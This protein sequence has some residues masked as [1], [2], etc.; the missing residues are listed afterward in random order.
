MNLKHILALGLTAAVIFPAAHGLSVSADTI[1][2]RTQQ[3]TVSTEKKIIASSTDNTSWKLYDDGELEINCTGTAPYFGPDFTYKNEVKS[4][5]I[6]ENVTVLPNI[7]FMNYPN[8]TTVKVKGSLSIGLSAFEGCKQLS[9]I[10][11]FKKVTTIDSHAFKNCINIQNLTFPEGVDSI[12]QSAFENCKGLEKVTIS[13]GS[14]SI[15]HQ[16]F[17]NCTNLSDL[18]IANGASII[19]EFAFKNCTN[20]STIAISNSAT[21]IGQGAFS[22]CSAL[23]TITLP[24]NL[25]AINASTFNGCK[26][27]NSITIPSKVTTIGEQAFLNCESLKKIEIPSNV[28]SIGESAFTDCT[29]LSIA[30]IPKEVTYIAP[31][32]FNGCTTLLSIRYTGTTAQWNN[33]GVTLLPPK[34]LPESL[35]NV[36]CNYTPNHKHTYC[37]YT[38]YSTPKST[39]KICSVCG[40]LQYENNT[41]PSPSPT[42]EHKW[43]GWTTISAATVF[44]GAVQRRTCSH[45]G[46]S[47]T[48]TGNKLAPTIRVNATSFP[49]KIKQKTTAFKASGFAN[50]DS[51]A[52]WKPSNTKVVS[53]S[54]S[55]NGSCKITAGKKTG[56]ATITITLKSGLKKNISVTV[57]KK[58]VTAKKITGVP[59]SLNLKA[60]KKASLKPVLNPITCADKVTYKTS[61]KKVATVTGKGQITAKKK[62]K[63]VITVKAGKKTVKCKVTVK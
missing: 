6:G 51:V 3:T 22:G 11:F 32:I 54:G 50:G 52:S 20:L 40:D 49:L 21:T 17:F 59:K 30:T 12:G 7:E 55:A 10:T 46:K 5:I 27:L 53:V 63:A 39:L 9:D 24:A 14:A 47:E 62:G 1:Q 15:G 4:V 42:E 41:T 57:Q 56:K 31:N 33:L 26:K 37:T 61:N 23:N 2:T 13:K 58:A 16:A 35:Q 44:K 45:C 29:N 38:I 34:T 8:L 19:G 43:S 25:T 36:Y 60:K 28:T 18:S 48:R